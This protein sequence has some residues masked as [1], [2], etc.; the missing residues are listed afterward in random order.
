MSDQRSDHFVADG[1]E[2]LWATDEYLQQQYA[3]RTRI[4]ASY[5]DRFAHASFW[6]RLRLYG[7]MRHEIERARAELASEEALYFHR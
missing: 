3:I 6:Q 2:R 1:R 7:Q 5:Q 4:R